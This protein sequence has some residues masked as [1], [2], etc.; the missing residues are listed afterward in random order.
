L[1]EFGQGRS[2]PE[3]ADGSGTSIPSHK[4]G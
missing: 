1:E 4:M 2:R 3:F